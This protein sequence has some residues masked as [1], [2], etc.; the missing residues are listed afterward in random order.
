MARTSRR[1]TIADARSLGIA[2]IRLPL[3]AR[4]TSPPAGCLHRPDRRLLHL[5]H[6]N[7]ADQR[8]NLLGPELVACHQRHITDPPK[9][10]EVVCAWLRRIR[11]LL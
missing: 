6:A 4:A 2:A 3:E 11:T 7:L 8:K 1:E 5:A 9:F 10:Q